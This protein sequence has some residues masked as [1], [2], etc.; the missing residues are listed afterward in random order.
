MILTSK[1]TDEIGETKSVITFSKAQILKSKRYQHKQDVVNVVLKADK[2][3]TL[4][5]VD[6]LIKKFY[7][8]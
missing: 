8:R 5:K 6:E 4:E 3:Y 1:K 2:A 7:E